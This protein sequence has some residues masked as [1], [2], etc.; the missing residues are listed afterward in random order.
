MPPKRELPNWLDSFVEWVLPRSEAPEPMIRWTGLYTLSSIM[1]RR[2][3]WPRELLG[4]YEVFPNLYLI[5]V[6]DPAVVRKSTTVGFSERLLESKEITGEKAVT[7]AATIT[8]HSKLLQA[9]ADSPDQSVAIVSSEFSSLIQT[10]PEHMYEILIELY[11]NKRKFEWSTW[12]HGDKS[13][14]NPVINLFAA[15]T[16]AWISGQPPEYFVEGGFASRV[17]FVY[18]EEPRQREIYYDHLNHKQLN[19]LGEQLIHDLNIIAEVK[20]A[21]EHDRKATKEY[22]RKW[23]KNQPTRPEDPRLKGFHGRKHTHAHK[24]AMLLNVAEKGDR[25]VTRKQWNEAVKLLDYVEKK[26]PQAFANLGMNPHATLM[27]KIL[28]YVEK[29]EKA[30][31]SEIAGRFYLEG[32]TL[33][34]LNSALTFL[35]V[36]GKLSAN[37]T[38][39]PTY[40]RKG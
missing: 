39:N 13:A 28:E 19:I 4:G 10:T 30:S 5:F 22:I 36:S 26:L 33:E 27:E 16:P 1:K 38:R 15:T 21:F 12:A 7:F 31:H 40:A 8:S 37:G 20:G 34:Q 18:E 11:D 25:K 17:I 2:I 23:Y 9:I 35:C 24:V 6:A 29:K 14:D 3:W 32:L